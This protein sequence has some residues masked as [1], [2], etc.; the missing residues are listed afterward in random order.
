MD[1]FGRQL[2]T[3]SN[4]PGITRTGKFVSFRTADNAV[5]LTYNPLEPSVVRRAVSAGSRTTTNIP[6]YSAPGDI[7]GR[8]FVDSVED[9]VFNPGEAALAGWTVF[10]DTN[11][12]GRLNPS[13]RA[14]AVITDAR[15]NYQFTRLPSL[16]DY[17]I[18]IDKPANWTVV[19][20]DASSQFRWDVS[21]QP[22]RL[23]TEEILHCEEL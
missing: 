13:E 20:P 7:S 4:Y 21:L 6:V 19:A 11:K 15:G 2:S 18:A 9:G 5:V 14:S 1:E 12:D 3:A 22:Q 17:S 16:T 10:I 23:S 8:V